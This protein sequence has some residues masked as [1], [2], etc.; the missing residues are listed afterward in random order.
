MIRKALIGIGIVI[1]AL[2]IFVVYLS[3]TTKSHSPEEISEFENDQIS[4]HVKYCRP[5]MKERLIFGSK[6]DGALV[7]YGQKWRTGANEA[8]EITFSKSVNFDGKTVPPGT[9]SVYTIPE[10]DAW[11]VALNEKIGFWGASFTGDPYDENLDVC[12]G[13][14]KTSSLETPV[15]QFGISIQDAGMDSLLVTFGWDRTQA[16]AYFTY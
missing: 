1:L 2:G 11:T 10:E 14:A 15:E 4:V 9:Y 7:P 13:Q 5:F 8:T 6:E 12:R 3:L 16:S